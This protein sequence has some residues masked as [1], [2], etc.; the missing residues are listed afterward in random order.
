MER[1][2]NLI[3][4]LSISSALAGLVLA[5]AI[6]SDLNWW[7]YFGSTC[8]PHNENHYAHV[9]ENGAASS[10]SSTKN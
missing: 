4:A 6:I 9:S 7:S 8:A 1:L 3:F 5:S 2:D 10:F